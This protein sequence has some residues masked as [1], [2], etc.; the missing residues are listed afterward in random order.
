MDAIQLVANNSPLKFLR[1]GHLIEKQPR[2][3]VVLIE[4]LLQLLDA[5][6]SVLELRVAHQHEN[7]GIRPTRAVECD[8][9]L[10]GRDCGSV[11]RG[12]P[13]PS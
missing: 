10:D 4:A 6:H 11:L 8:H 12:L 5:S 1:K 13:A 7:D 2:V 3:A 9:I